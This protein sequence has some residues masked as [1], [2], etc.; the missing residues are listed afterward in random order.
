MLSFSCQVVSDSLQSHG[1]QHS[2]LPCP[3]NLLEFAYSC[4][5]SW[6]C[7]PTISSSVTPFLLLSSIFP[8]SSFPRSWPFTAGGQSIETSASAS[9]L[10]MNIQGWFLFRIDWFDFL[11]LQ[12]TLKSLLQH[13]N[14]KA[15]ILWHSTLFMV[16]LS[17]PYMITEKTIALIIWTFVGKVI[18]L[19]FNTRFVIAFLPRS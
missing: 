5:V 10:P 11:A 13:R 12:G 14:S 17:H 2:R 18:S 4:P 16:Q 7:H 8:A 3:S 6:W 19:L 1:L 9:V 15:S